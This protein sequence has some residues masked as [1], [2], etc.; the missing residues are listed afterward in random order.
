MQLR[1]IATEKD[2]DLRVLKMFE[3]AARDRENEL[4]SLIRSIN[5][6]G[7]RLRLEK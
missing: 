7:I 2:N 3:N 5:S 4:D 1:S 6:A